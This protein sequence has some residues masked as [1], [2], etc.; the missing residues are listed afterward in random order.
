MADG[1]VKRR[2]NSL[3]WGTD[4]RTLI[5]TPGTTP[6]IPISFGGEV[7]TQPAP[8]NTSLPV[9]TG[10][11]VVGSTL[12][13]TTGSWNNAV[14]FA[15]Q[16]KL[17]GTGIVGATAS[18]YV[19]QAGDTGGDI[20]CT[21]TATG[22]GGNASATSGQAQVYEAEAS[23]LFAKMTTSPASVPRK[24]YMNTLIV[25]LKA[26]GIFSRLEAMWI[27]AAHSAEAAALDWKGNNARNLIGVGSPT[28]STDLGFTYS[29]LNYHRTGVLPASSSNLTQNSG[30][31]G[32]MTGSTIVATRALGGARVGSA[33]NQII[34]VP[35]LSGG[36]TARVNQDTGPTPI[37]CPPETANIAFLGHRTFS[38]TVEHIRSGAKIGDSTATSS[39]R[40]NFEVYI[41]AVNES[42]SLVLQLQDS[43]RWFS[44]GLN[45]TT[46]QAQYYTARIETYMAGLAA[47]A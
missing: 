35:R 17:N 15:Y 45:F 38:N 34:L 9:V 41:G 19:T 12:T 5:R 36:F 6:H 30:H 8:V 40:T 21:V 11:D 16:W 33:A 20:T 42:G 7:V 10:L 13:A 32:G 23:A 39:V 14:S 1:V 31:I 18:T 25:D 43:I 2:L 37:A 28:F 3:R 29:G 24:K 4:R 47:N 27:P 46:A 26:Q 22:P 44:L